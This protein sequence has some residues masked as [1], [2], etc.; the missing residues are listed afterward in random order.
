MVASPIS[1]W[2]TVKPSVA[3]WDRHPRYKARKPDFSFRN[4]LVEIMSFRY[5]GTDDLKIDL[6]NGF[7]TE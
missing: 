3:V 5:I 6:L 1:F 2:L 7:Y 4:V